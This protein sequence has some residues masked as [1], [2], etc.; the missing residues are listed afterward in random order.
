[1]RT[2]NAF[3]IATYWKVVRRIVEFEQGGEKRTGYGEELLD[4]LAVDFNSWLDRGFCRRN[5][6][7]MRQF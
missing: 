3:M 7:S 2:V 1:V 5:L 4:L 6:Q